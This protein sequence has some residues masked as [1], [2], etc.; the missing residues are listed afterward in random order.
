MQFNNSIFYKKVYDIKTVI[1]ISTDNSSLIMGVNSENGELLQFHYGRKISNPSEVTIEG[2]VQKGKEA[3]P[4]YS[5]FGGADNSPVLRVS[6]SD[7]NLS[8]ELI[9]DSH[10]SS[11]NL[12][13]I[14]LKDKHY[15]FFVEL[16]YLSYP[17][18]DVIESWVSFKNCESDEI[19]LHEYPSVELSFTDQYS[20]YFLTTFYG[21]WERENQLQNEQLSLGKKIFDNR[22]G[23]WSS[24]GYNPSFMLSLDTPSTETAGE[25]IAGAL[26]WSGSWRI[27]F[28]YNQG[29]LVHDTTERRHLSITAGVDSFAADYHL[30]PNEQF[31]TPHFIFTYSDSGKGQASRNLHNWSRKKCIRQSEQE[32]PIL[33]NSWEGAYFNFDET[34]LL[35]MMDRA[36][37]VGIEMFVLDDGW[38]GNGENA[39]NGADAGLGDWQVNRQKLPNGLTFLANEA[40]KRNLQ[41]GIWVEPEM[42]NPQSELFVKHPEWVIQQPNREQLLYRNQLLLDLSNP[43]VQ[44][45]VYESVANILIENPGIS[46]VK[47]DCNRSFTN[48][49]SMYLAK[50]RQ[51]HL[52][53]DYVNGL[54]AV[55]EK[56]SKTF[57]DTIFQACASGGGRVDYGILKYNHEFWTSDNTD[58]LQRVFIQWG[59]SHI[60]PAN[61][62]AAH[63]SI[64]PNHQ[65]GR[66]TPIKFRF[67]IAMSGRLGMELNPNEVS[68]EETNFSQNA[69]KTY[70]QIRQTVQHGDLYRLVSPY[71]FDYASLMY[72]NHNRSEAVLFAY[73]TNHRLGNSFYKIKLQ[74]LDKNLIY[75]ID[76]INKGDKDHLKTDKKLLSGDYLMNSGISVDLDSE[77]DSLVIRLRTT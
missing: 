33:L 5:A 53:V 69:I 10:K 21:L 64:S 12:T 17:K 28:D 71:E 16:N 66:K 3:V 52:W 73:N 57:P 35:A 46:Y 4:V 77:Y 48:V 42:V 76:E 49:G 29:K 18:E 58:P 63:V 2:V 11:D 65:T 1:E 67:D 75:Q 70:K 62:T 22:Y 6:H 32:R 30:L 47:W 68:C 26:A 36:S 25:V 55:Y 40:K 50:N 24:F 23:T 59:I 8:T 37:E 31:E 51:T 19:V 72:V 60:Y 54:Y 20:N 34:T 7:G 13:T 56:L 44:N 9:Y 39:R 27:C 41:F 43:D 61:A 45:H 14:I 38:F 15:P 74:G